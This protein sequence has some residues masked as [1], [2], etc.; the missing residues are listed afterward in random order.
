MTLVPTSE[1]APFVPPFLSFGIVQAAPL[2]APVCLVRAFA[3]R[4]HID[5]HRI[6]IPLGLLM[7][8]SSKWFAASILACAE[9][10]TTSRSEAGHHHSSTFNFASCGCL[11]VI[12]ARWNWISLGDGVMDSL[13]ESLLKHLQGSFRTAFPTSANDKVLKGGN[14]FAYIVVFHFEFH[15]V[16]VQ[17]LTVD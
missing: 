11:P 1:A 2:L 6:R 9:D 12:K 13:S 17:L 10:V 7:R 15:Q 16:T 5:I 4:G 14:V 8:W 3:N